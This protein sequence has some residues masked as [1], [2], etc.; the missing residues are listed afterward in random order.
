MTLREALEALPRD[1]VA[2]VGADSGYV[3]IARADTLRETD[4]PYW[5]AY[6]ARAYRK[7]LEEHRRTL[8]RLLNDGY[9]VPGLAALNDPKRMNTEGYERHARLMTWEEYATDYVKWQSN[10]I[11]EFGR[12]IFRERQEVTRAEKRMARF[13][14][15]SERAVVERRM[16]M[17]VPDETILILATCHTR[18]SGMFWMRGEYED[19]KRT[20]R[21]PQ[22]RANTAPS[23]GLAGGTGKALSAAGGERYSPP[24]ALDAHHPPRQAGAGRTETRLAGTTPLSVLAGGRMG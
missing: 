21:L 24:G 10:Q 2:R 1:A 5:D 11:L 6:Y 14:P 23:E 20:G 12:R 13:R 16:S 7:L 19:W 15:F 18:D 22:E 3:A 17:E 9:H 4:M 8:A